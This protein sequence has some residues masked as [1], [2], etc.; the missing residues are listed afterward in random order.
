MI[1]FELKKNHININSQNHLKDYLIANGIE[2]VESFL[3]GP[4]KEDEES[5]NNLDH[6]QEAIDALHKGF[7][8]NKKFFL[9]CDSDVDGYTSAAIFHAFFK[10]IYPNADIVYRL[11]DEKEHGVILDT[12]PV[13]ADY[14]IVP[15]A[16]S[17][18]I[19]EMEQLSAKGYTTIIMDHHLMT[20]GYPNIDNVII[21]NN[22]G[23]KDFK[24]KGLSGAGIVYKVIQAYNDKYYQANPKLFR[25]FTDLAA[26]GIVSDMMDTRELDNHYIIETGRHSLVNPMFEA[27][28]ARQSFSVKD[29]NSPTKIDMAF[30]IAPLIN[31]IVRVGTEEEK[32]ILFKGFIQYSTDEIIKTVYR[33]EERRETLHEYIAR[34]AFNARA[35]QNRQKEKC[36]EFLSARIEKNNAQDNQILIV[37]A[38]NTDPV[39]MPKTITGLVAME[40]MKKYQR[41]TLVLRPKM[42]DGELYY[43]GSGRGKVNGRFTAFKDFLS[44]SNLV[45]F[46]EGHNMAFGT[47]VSEKN[48]PKLIAYANEKLADIEFSM[49]NVEVDVILDSNNFN[50]EIIKS[51]AYGEKIYGN[52]IPQPKIGVDILVN[53]QAANII[54]KNEDTFKIFYEGVEFITFRNNDI[55]KKYLIEKEK[56]KF[57]NLKGVGRAQ[58]NT[59]Q[60]NVTPQVVL[61]LIDITA[62]EDGGDYGYLF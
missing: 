2:K 46:A 40:L 47:S 54:G 35:R 37:I 33:N 44:E 17:N 16:G 31:A 22:Q 19:D 25:K 8:N 32:D 36:M 39:P 10:S 55:V 21:V 60:Y 3:Y 53:V 18:Q 6:V 15:D 52:G 42:Q 11:H 41:P 59:W 9:Q 34:I 1:N 56:G 23:S 51:F 61:D 30:Y 50:S 49:E 27:L 4:E 29:I 62:Q 43:M 7:T 12:I 26:L 14:V 38:S 5:Y 24:N 20:Y 58:L 48:L 13:D 45:E 28:L 57:L